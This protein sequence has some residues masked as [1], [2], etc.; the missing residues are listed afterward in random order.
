MIKTLSSLDS[1][2]KR[3]LVRVDLNVPVKDGKVTDST[4]IERIVPT[5]EALQPANRQI[6]LLSHF[7]RPKNGYDEKFSLKQIVPKIEE[8]LKHKV[9]FISD[10]EVNLDDAKPGIYLLE[11]T[12]FY[13]GEE[14]NSSELANKLA[15]FADVYVNDAFSA[16]HR[17]HAS[18]T[19]IANILPSYAGISL[20]QELSALSAGLDAPQQPLTAIVGG[21]KISTKIDLLSN[22]VKKVDNLVIGGGMANTFLAAKGYDVGASLCEHDAIDKAKQIISAAKE[23]NCNIV[24]P[25]DAIVAK[26]FSNDVATYERDID[27]IEISDMILDIGTKSVEKIKQV[28]NQSKTIIWNGPVGAFEVSN[29]A[30]G[31]IA[32]AQLIAKL[33]KEGHIVSVAGGGDTVYALSVAGVTSALTYVSTAGGAFLEWMEGKTLPAI[34]VLDK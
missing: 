27:A 1:S 25:I 14:S 4:R 29:F 20:E 17:A 12:R 33:T 22:L 5:I 8:I 16:S 11:N 26:E 28:I 30:N 32:I 13:D 19:A 21:A 7:G 18:T 2:I 3:V 6:V 15:K 23:H 31:T 34:A 9:S 24:L 10:M